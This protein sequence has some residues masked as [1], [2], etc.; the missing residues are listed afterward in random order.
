[1]TSIDTAHRTP[2]RVTTDDENDPQPA[3]A[4]Y[5]DRAERRCSDTCGQSPARQDLDTIWAFVL[6]QG[7]TT[8]PLFRETHVSES[9]H[10][11]TIKPQPDPIMKVERLEQVP[12]WR[13]ASTRVGCAVPAACGWSTPLVAVKRRALSDATMARIKAGLRRYQDLPPEPGH[14]PLSSELAALLR[15]FVDRLRHDDS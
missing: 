5:I 6:K 3:S 11:L 1:M 15:V 8:Y 10:R 12:G 14:R 4:T 13:Y 7:S 2:P 9:F